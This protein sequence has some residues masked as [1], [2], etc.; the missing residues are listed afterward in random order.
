MA[1]S[2]TET[3]SII[4]LKSPSR[5]YGS[6]TGTPWKV[7]KQLIYIENQYFSS[8]AIYNALAE[9][10]DQP[11][12]S[13]LNIVIMLPRNAHAFLE[14]V[15]IIRTQ[16]W[17]LESLL[18]LA[19]RTGHQMGIFSTMP[20][21]YRTET[22]QTYVHAKLLIIDDR[23]LMV[24]SAN[25]NN[26]GMGLDT[27]INLSWEARDEHDIKFVRSV[28]DARVSLLAEHIGG[29]RRLK[30]RIH[31]TEGLV[32]FLNAVAK[33]RT[34]VYGSMFPRTNKPQP[35]GSEKL[36]MPGLSIRN[37]RPW[38]REFTR[39]FHRNRTGS[40]QIP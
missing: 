28:R 6:F 40:S 16:T 20:D 17:I 13:R 21:G 24:G 1:I 7:P 36:R 25:T 11:G 9:R 2:R 26:R 19:G 27:E 10:M 35:T 12:R 23:F 39:S 30:H 8:R 37:S 34:L 15:S 29:G 33:K 14:K 31:N 32:A 22:E 38:K 5:K 3:R 4:L 18:D